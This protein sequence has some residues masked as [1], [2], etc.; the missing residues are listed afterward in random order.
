M[1]III[2]TIFII[3]YLFLLL[4][5]CIFVTS[6]DKTYSTIVIKYLR[7]IPVLQATKFQ[8]LEPSHIST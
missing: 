6:E 5:N 3:L 1:L 8:Y 4:Q 7:S 2:I